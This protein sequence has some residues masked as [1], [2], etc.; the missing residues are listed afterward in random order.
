MHERW[1]RELARACLLPGQLAPY[2]RSLD[3]FHFHPSYPPARN[4]DVIINPPHCTTRCTPLFRIPGLNPLLTSHRRTPSGTRLRPLSPPPP[5][6]TP[7]PSPPRPQPSPLAKT[8]IPLPFLGLTPNNRPASASHPSPLSPSSPS[9]SNPCI[10]AKSTSSAL[11]RPGSGPPGSRRPSRGSWMKKWK[12]K[13]LS[14][15]R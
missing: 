5:Q 7:P 13:R 4:R 11:A 9:M 2:S 1:G 3:L 12:G 15:R 10:S 6:P 14:D 8:S